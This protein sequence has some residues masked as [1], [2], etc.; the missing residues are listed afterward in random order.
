LQ[1]QTYGD[2]AGQHDEGGSMNWDRIEGQWKQVKGN[3]K[4]RWGD[5]TDDRIEQAAGQRDKFIGVIQ[6][7][8]GISRDA[9]EKEVREWEA[10]L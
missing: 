7:Q 3:I 10:K 1:Q 5:L 4:E 6:E 8:Y 2:M 9:A